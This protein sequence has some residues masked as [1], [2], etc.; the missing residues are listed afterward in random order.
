MDGL[1][2]NNIE[3]NRKNLSDLAIWEPASFEALAKISKDFVE[4]EK[5]K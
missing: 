4:K 5:K 1:H 3:I 2:K